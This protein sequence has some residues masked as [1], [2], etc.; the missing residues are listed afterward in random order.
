MC[1]YICNYKVEYRKHKDYPEKKNTQ[2]ASLLQSIP[3]YRSTYIVRVH[4]IST[5]LRCMEHKIPQE[6]SWFPVFVHGEVLNSLILY[7]IL[8]IFGHNS[9]MIHTRIA[10]ALF[11]R[12][13]EFF[14][15]YQRILFCLF[16]Y[17]E[18]QHSVTVNLLDSKTSRSLYNDLLLSHFCVLQEKLRK[19]KQLRSYLL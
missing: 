10:Y 14:L 9:N 6:R 2:K 11:P 3:P 12:V 7:L 1:K 15:F 13:L 18:T 16:L 5:G 4:S 19:V 8:C 17:I